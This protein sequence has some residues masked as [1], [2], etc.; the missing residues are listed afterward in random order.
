MRRQFRNMHHGMAGRK[1]FRAQ[2]GMNSTD[3]YAAGQ[4]AAQAAWSAGGVNA[5]LAFL[6]GFNSG[7]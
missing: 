1:G 3:F 7:Q 5:L 6:A 4:Q 2:S